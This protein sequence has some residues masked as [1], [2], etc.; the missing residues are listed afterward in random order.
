MKG[1]DV[2]EKSN[3]A[4]CETST[5]SNK[6]S[7]DSFW[8]FLEREVATK[9]PTCFVKHTSPVQS[10][11]ISSAVDDADAGNEGDVPVHKVPPRNWR[12]VQ[13]MFRVLLAMGDV[14][15]ISLTINGETGLYYRQDD[16]ITSQAQTYHFIVAER[17]REQF[18]WYTEY[19]CIITNYNIYVKMCGMSN[20]DV[21]LAVWET[22]C[23]RPYH[24]I[25][26]WRKKE[27]D[28][29]LFK[30]PDYRRANP[31]VELDPT[32]EFD[33]DKALR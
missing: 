32:M 1:N 21:I 24:A 26:V 25:V 4:Q 9:R 30:C 11:D 13:G 2:Q 6:P 12:Q 10:H 14:D 16:A 19:A 27:D 20:G 31:N 5:G 23:A 33:K 18:Y 7:G 8:Q 17:E 22:R 29:L 3:V 15:H 28:V